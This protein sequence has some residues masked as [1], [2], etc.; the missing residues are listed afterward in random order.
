MRFLIIFIILFPFISL[1][2]EGKLNR[3]GCHNIPTSIKEPSFNY[4]CHSEQMEKKD[5]SINFT[6]NNKKT[7]S[8]FSYLKIIFEYL[9]P[10]YGIVWGGSAI[11]ELIRN[12]DNSIF[13]WI[14]SLF[15]L[16]V[17]IAWIPIVIF[18]FR[19]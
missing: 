1:S 5:K 11:F 7:T 19:I 6:K 15:I 8:V 17:G 2:H 3:Y 4:H 12:K 13:I 14:Y 9:V 10:I 16:F 18:G